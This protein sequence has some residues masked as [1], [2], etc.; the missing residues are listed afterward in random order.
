MY[1]FSCSFNY[2]RKVRLSKFTYALLFAFKIE[3]FLIQVLQPI[4]QVLPVLENGTL[5]FFLNSELHLAHS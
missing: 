1:S 2:K 5:I 3:N 4:G